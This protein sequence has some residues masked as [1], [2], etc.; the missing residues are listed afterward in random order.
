MAPFLGIRF[1]EKPVLSFLGALDTGGLNAGL[2]SAGS[3]GFRSVPGFRGSGGYHWA[4]LHTHAA[5]TETKQNGRQVSLVWTS[6]K[7]ID[8]DEP[9]LILIND[10]EERPHIL[11]RACVTATTFKAIGAFG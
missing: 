1:W 10:H 11:S 4:W 8:V 3:G 7:L 5:P 9:I 2:G 6:H